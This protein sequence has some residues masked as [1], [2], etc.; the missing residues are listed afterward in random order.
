MDPDAP[1][2]LTTGDVVCFENTLATSSFHD[3]RFKRGPP[4]TVATRTKPSPPNVTLTAS[5]TM[6]PPSSAQIYY[7]TLPTTLTDARL[8]PDLRLRCSDVTAWRLRVLVGGLKTLQ[9]SGVRVE[10]KRAE[11]N[12]G[13]G[14]MSVG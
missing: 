2:A 4:T 3:P 9:K 12:W 6:L 8:R 13:R 14:R 1:P 5:P 10:G 11:C 7:R